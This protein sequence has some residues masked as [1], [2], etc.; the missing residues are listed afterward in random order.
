MMESV[1]DDNDDYYDHMNNVVGGE[2]L[3]SY[4]MN[5]RKTV[6]TDR[7]NNALSRSLDAGSGNGAG[8]PNRSLIGP[9]DAQLSFS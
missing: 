8:T 2:L 6:R 5:R 4:R 3:I 1:E 9:D 7:M